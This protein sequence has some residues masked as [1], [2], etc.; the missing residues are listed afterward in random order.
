MDAY[1]Q[2]LNQ[3]ISTETGGAFAATRVEPVAGGDIC[4]AEVID[5]GSRRFFV[6]RLP[7]AQVGLFEAEAAGLAA[8]GAHLRVPAVIATGVAAG[9]AYLVL[10]ALTLCGRGDAA[11]LGCALAALH[12]VP[13]HGY[14]WPHDNWIGRSAQRNGVQADWIEFWRSRRLGVQL[15]LAAADGHGGRLQRD[16]ERLLADLPAFF[17][18]YTP[19]A[20]LLHGDLW[21]G[22]HAYL[23]DGTPVLFDPAV[24]VGDREAD[25]AMTEL[26]GGYAPEFYAAYRA[27]WPLDPGYGVRKTLY[28]LYHVLNH[29][30]L[31]GGGYV[32]QAARM[33]ATLVA[34]LR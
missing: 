5:D 2:A 33:T 19:A 21:G 26:F 13:Q 24:Y 3:R 25:L 4:A 23:Q 30:H 11:G 12:R 7:A 9:Q 15:A 28:N 29:A 18:G 14:G 1:L 17:A 16:G 10:E 20:S 31:F 8:L 32:A 27:A 34:E 6:K 22:N